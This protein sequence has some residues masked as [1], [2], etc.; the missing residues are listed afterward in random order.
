M[1][2]CL[3]AS[4]GFGVEHRLRT[5]LAEPAITRGWRLAVTLT[6]T[7]A[8][9]L[10]VTGELARLRALTDLPVRSVGRLPGE[11]SPYGMADRYLFVPA[12]A[13]SIAKLALGIADNQALTQLCEAVGTASV[14]VV[15]RPQAGAA[16]RGHPAFAGHLVTL[17]AAGVHISDADPTA[18]WTPLLDEI[19]DRVRS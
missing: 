15:V 13:N 17:R 9:W 19:A 3:V 1:L 5:E 11:P 8:H 14:P 2:L 16:Q 4:G 18:P 12:T 6:P 10:D 7:A